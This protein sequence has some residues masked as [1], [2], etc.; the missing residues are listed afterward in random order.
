MRNA[1]GT[2][3]IR[4]GTGSVTLREGIEVVRGPFAVPGPGEIC[5]L[6]R[7]KTPTEAALRMRAWRA[8][9]KR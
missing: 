1:L 7:E 4:D 3:E 8:K 5:P 9:R 2:E 6:C